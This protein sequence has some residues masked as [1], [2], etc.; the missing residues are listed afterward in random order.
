MKPTTLKWHGMISEYGR[1]IGKVEVLM[2]F[3]GFVQMTLWG[4]R[5][6]LKNKVCLLKQTIGPFPGFFP[7]QFLSNFSSGLSQ[8][9]THC[10]KF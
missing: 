4:C 5:Y 2:V 7:A 8:L 10:V 6:R 9:I 1:G 3:G